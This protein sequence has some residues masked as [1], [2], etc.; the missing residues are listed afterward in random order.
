[1]ESEKSIP[2]PLTGEEI[3]EAV[4]FKLRECMQKNC[5]LS[6]GNAYTSAKIDIKISMTLFDYGREVRNNEIAQVHLD[7]ELPNES[8][9]QEVTGELITD[10]MP[11]NLLRQEVDLPVPVE[12]VIDGKKVTKHLKHL[13]YAPRKAKV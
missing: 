2:L 8:A 7:S 11:P 4:V 13:K 6:L 3:Q 12:S 10:P 1:M 5:H 9:A